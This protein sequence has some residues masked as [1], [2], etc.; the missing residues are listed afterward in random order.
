[1][2]SE[3]MASAEL[4]RN[5][6]I[7]LRVDAEPFAIFIVIL[8][9]SFDPRGVRIDVWSRAFGADAVAARDLYDSS[10]RKYCTPEPV[11]AAQ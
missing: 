10:V 5:R 3:V 6:V 8:H 4:E 2:N 9:V 1:M 7:L 11:E